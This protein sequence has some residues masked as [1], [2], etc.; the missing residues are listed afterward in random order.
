MQNIFL[1]N[2]FYHI[3][4]QDF[5]DLKP[6][7]IK[8]GIDPTRPDLTFGHLVILNKLAQFQKAGHKIVL[9]IGD[10]TAKIGDPSGRDNT[11]PI[12][13][14]DEI[15]FNKE[16]YLNQVFKI[17][18]S[19][20]TE[21]HNNSEWYNNFNIQKFLDLIKSCTVSQM[22][23]RDDFFKRFKSNN[24][25]SI[26]EFIYPI[27]QGYDSFIVNAD[28]EVGGQDQ[29]F[30]LLM[31]RKIQKIYSRKEQ[32][33]FTYPL[34]I[35]TDGVKKMSK[36]YDNYIAFNDSAKDIFGKI[37]SIPDNLIC[38][39]YK[40]LISEEVKEKP[41]VSKYYLAQKLVEKFYGKEAALQEFINFKNIFS[42]KNIP[43]DI[44]TIYVDN[45]EPICDIMFK[46]GN[47]SSK[48]E[49]RRLLNDGAVKDKDNN[50]FS[51]ND[52]INFDLY[53]SLVLKIGKKTFLKILKKKNNDH[54]NIS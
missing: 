20:Q 13:S 10:F 23:E 54:S 53:N 41:P 46:T 17:I 45:F 12:L 19:E 26:L 34:L 44:P 35:G 50:K 43:D 51:I 22:L 38:D 11:R 25:I 21:V 1:E 40:Y 27:L 24:P 42:N 33:I 4:N 52:K 30:N 3:I 8:F 18:S 15:K 28:I 49:C 36:S 31:G 7:R 16:T 2:S 5:D 37:M 6:A 29:L 48:N 9:I 47:Y 39:Y 14:D 32:N